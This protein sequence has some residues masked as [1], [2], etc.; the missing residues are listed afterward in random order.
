MAFSVSS[1]LSSGSFA[2]D[3]GGCGVIGFGGMSL[4]AD[5]GH[6]HGAQARRQAEGTK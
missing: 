5:G 3:P 4:A 6:N 2:A 1:S